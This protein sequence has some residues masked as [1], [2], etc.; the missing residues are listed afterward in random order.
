MSAELVEFLLARIA[1]DETAARKLGVSWFVRGDGYRTP[2]DA[3]RRVLDAE[4]RRSLVG[5]AR[6]LDA[7]ISTGDDD[8]LAKNADTVLRNLGVP[9][10]YHPDYRPEWRP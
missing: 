1:E 8:A 9:Y 10:S 5:L 4:A 7:E 2:N 6:G 3:A